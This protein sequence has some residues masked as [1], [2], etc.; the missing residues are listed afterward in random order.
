MTGRVAVGAVEAGRDRIVLGGGCF[1]CTEA[2]LTELRGVVSA[3]PGYAGGSVPGPSYE[4]VC[5]GS[6][7]H[8]EVVEVTYEPK[9]LSLADLLGIFFATHDPTT[10]NRQG[11]DV[12]TQYRSI[13][14]Y[15]TPEQRVEAER[16]AQEAEAHWGRPITTQILPLE[17]FYPAEEYH[18]DYFRRNPGQGYCRAVIAPKVAKVRAAYRARLVRPA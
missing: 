7:G 10:L 13:V 6:T 2:V 9:V 15:R 16:A 4:Q 5:E 3:E 8:A 18:R 12:G 1:W 17:A 14:L 11:A